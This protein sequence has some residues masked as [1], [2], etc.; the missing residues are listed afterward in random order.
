MKARRTARRS[1]VA[2]VA[3]IGLVTVGLVTF[4]AGPTGAGARP[5]AQAPGGDPDPGAAGPQ[6]IDELS[7]DLGELAFRPEGFSAA[8]EVRA[9]VYAPEVIAAPAPLVV[10]QHGRH[11]T[12]GRG[13]DVSAEWPCPSVRP[14]IPSYRG[15]DALG[16]LLA[17]YGAI[18]VSIG[19]N[20]INA[21]DDFSTDGGASARG[22]L[23]LEHLR[24][25][26]EWNGSGAGPFG[27]RFVGRVDLG[28]V[29]LMGHSRGGEGVVT[30]AQINQRRSNPYGI[31]AVV[32]L[33]PVD[34]DRRVLGGVALQVVLPFCDG[35]VSDLQGTGYY[36]DSRYATPGDFAPKQTT[37]LYGANHNFFNTVWTTGPGSFDDSE[38]VFEGGSPGN[39]GCAPGG[40]GR[41]SAAEQSRAGATIMG[42][43]LRRYLFADASLQP[44]VTGVSPFPPSALP[45]R[46][47]VAFHGG[48]RLDVARW[49]DGGDSRTN[50]LGRPT[51]VRGASPGIVCSGVGGGFFDGG[52]G[53][54]GGPQRVVCP[55]DTQLANFSAALDVGWIRPTASVRLDLP[56]AGLDAS[57][58][59][60]LR[61]RIGFPVDSRNDRRPRQDLSIRLTD[62]SGA[63]ATVA[64]GPRTNAVERRPAS[65]L[66]HTVLNGVRLPLSAFTGLDLTRLARVEVLFDRFG[67]GRALLSDMAFTAEGTGA[68]V[69]PTEG[70][71]TGA[72]PASECR[73][74]AAQAWACAVGAVMWGREPYGGGEVAGL[75]SFY[76]DPARRAARIRAVVAGPT[77]FKTVVGEVAESLFEE[78]YQ[79]FVLEEAGAT[80]G[81]SW[82]E[83]IVSVG[84]F[85]GGST[86]ETRTLEG[87]VDAGYLAL[88]ERLPDAAGRAYW[89]GRVQA[90]DGP[91]AFIRGLVGSTERAGRVLDGRFLQILGRSVDA[92]ARRFWVPRLRVSGGEQS[93]VAS[94]LRSSEFAATPTP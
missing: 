61:F 50:R 85:F 46:W 84:R 71:G 48:P 22:Q 56:A 26:E 11:V 38:F 49:V 90:E 5:A 63:S 7:Y 27:A 16:R 19:A 94:L 33:A 70:A 65:V 66:Q 80:G 59:D 14:E 36:D 82:E 73:R 69:G 35:D 18:V 87:V 4:G 79:P 75:A 13:A 57:A 53:G 40:P 30:A 12:C 86:P 88:L 92:G 31:D 9:K 41:L 89:L 91:A 6:A 43:F 93:L 83:G 24:L 77:A 51:L 52:G 64:V 45:A 68:R 3:L 78:S 54:S 55:G 74:G 2:L 81:G 20:G 47:A 28:R 15:Y 17:S 29:G 21:N 60:S 76:A 39:D 58:H 42:G 37:L 8:V 10:I 62:L 34:F 23:V 25:W 32:A 1:G 44:F 72:P 67:S